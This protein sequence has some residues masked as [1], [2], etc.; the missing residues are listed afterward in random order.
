MRYN[1]NGCICDSCGSLLMPKEV[2]KIKTQK[3]SDDPGKAS[4]GSYTSFDKMDLCEN[5]YNELF[6][7]LMKSAEVKREKAA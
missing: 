7:D 1:G 4:S 3:L 6:A 5:C 2:I